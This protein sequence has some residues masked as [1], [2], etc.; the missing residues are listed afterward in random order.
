MRDW[1][2]IATV[3]DGEFVAARRLLDRFVKVDRT[4]YF[5]VL[6]GKVDDTAGFLRSLADW[7]SSHPDQAELLGHVGVF[8]LTFSFQ[9]PEEF[10]TQARAAAES[11][12]PRLANKR[13]HVR[14]HRRGFKGQLATPDEERF[15][16]GVLLGALERAGTPGTITFE[17]P[18]AIVALETIDNR[19]GFAVYEREELLRYPF[20]HL[21]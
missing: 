20:L 7:F 4:H 1:N 21:D 16:D 13:F 10:E 8:P 6:I 11:F 2:V 15:L 3:R 5:N 17:D 19:A 12:V 14:F 18:D 9:S